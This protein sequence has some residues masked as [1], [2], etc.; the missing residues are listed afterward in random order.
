METTVRYPVTSVRNATNTIR[1][2]T[3]VGKNVYKLERLYVV[4]AKVEGSI[5]YGKLWKFF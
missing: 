5:C 2:V 3:G 1:K 4:G